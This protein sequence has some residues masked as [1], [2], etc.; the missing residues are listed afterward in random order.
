MYTANAALELYA[1]AFEEAHALDRLEA[2]ASFFGPDFYGLPRNS[3]KI[4][5]VR[6]TWRMPEK[7]PFGGDELVPLRAGETLVW[8]LD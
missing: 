4:R 6:R 2:F 8:Q 3:G 5:L 7:L 1:A